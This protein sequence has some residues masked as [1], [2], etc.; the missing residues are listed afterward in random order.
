MYRLVNRIKNPKNYIKDIVFDKEFGIHN[1]TVEHRSN[2]PKRDYLFV[3]KKQCKH[4]PASPS[5]MVEMCKLLANKVNNTLANV[6]PLDEKVLVIGFAETA[7]AIGN[8]VADNLCCDA[9]VLQTTR[10]DVPNSVEIIRFEEEHSHATTQK[11]LTYAENPINLDDYVYILFVEDEI[12]TG[13]TILNFIDAF[14]AKHPGFRYGVASIC[15]WQNTENKEKFKQRGIDVF[16]LISGNLVDKDLK[17]IDKEDIEY[18]VTTSC[19][20]V[21]T[22]PYNIGC[23]PACKN[24]LGEDLFRE[25]RLGHNTNMDLTELFKYVEGKVK[26]VSAKSIRIIG[27]EEFMYIPIKVGEYLESIGC[28]VICHSTTRSPIDKVYMNNLK[29]SDAKTCSC[30]D[31]IVSK[32]TLDSVYDANRNTYLYNLEEMTD[33]IFIITDKEIKDS[34]TLNKY[35]Y[36][37]HKLATNIFIVQL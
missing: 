32:F 10:E 7:T 9:Y 1:I 19:D 37:L 33:L 13:N 36:T 22:E 26:A 21:K 18:L 15:N 3:N 28:E 4:I 27:T 25:T 8:C 31:T 14:E 29:D 34:K 11:L 30:Y 23:N 20:S 35:Y 6:V 5:E 2:N 24:M 12:S 16:A 17:L